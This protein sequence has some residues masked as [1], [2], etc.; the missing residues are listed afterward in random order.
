M[1]DQFG[2][3]AAPNTGAVSPTVAENVQHPD[4]PSLLERIKLGAA[5]TAK[6]F[7]IDMWLARQTP[8]KVVPIIDK[9][10][11]GAREQFADAVANGG[12]V[13]GVGYCVG[14]KYLLLLL[15]SQK[16]QSVGDE[17]KA[18]DA[19]EPT[20]KAGALAHGAMITKEDLEAVRM[21][22]AMVCVSEDNL[23]PDEIREQGKAVLEL[24]SVV[25]DVRVFEGVP[26]GFAIAGDYGESHIQSSQAEAFQMMCGWLE[27]H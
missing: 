22:L 4:N 6:S 20:L 12:G 2:D 10:L 1:P 21:P 9:A 23:F 25:H 16:R 14:A 11:E 15:G 17:E 18:G 3:D 26:H 24:N 8:E 5:E 7:R 19:K 13:Y 27:S